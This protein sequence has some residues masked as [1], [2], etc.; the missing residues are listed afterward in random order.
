MGELLIA[1]A[2]D[3]ER[4]LR[5]EHWSAPTALAIVLTYAWL[6]LLVYSVTFA[7]LWELPELT[8]LEVQLQP[9]E[10]QVQPKPVPPPQPRVVKPP[11]T[12]RILTAPAP[13][14]PVAP[15]LPLPPDPAPAAENVAPAPVETAAPPPEPA[16]EPQPAPIKVERLSRLTR[17]PVAT[18]QVEPLFP[19]SERLQQRQ[20]RVVA[21]YVIDATGAVRDI[22]IVQSAGA[23]FDQAAIAALRRCRFEPGYIDDRPVAIRL[24]QGFDF[25]FK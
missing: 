17:Q 5:W 25:K 22:K 19:E 12:P 2:Y 11:P 16:P 14:E 7:P 21:E 3:E 1:S 9:E 10:P 15:P 23:A 20:A 6:W 4:A 24:Q 18:Q 13:L 8:P